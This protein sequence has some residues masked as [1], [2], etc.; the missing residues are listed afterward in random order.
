MATAITLK[1]GSGADTIN[2]SFVVTGINT[3]RL[4][5]QFADSVNSLLTGGNPLTLLH[6]F[7]GAGAQGGDQ[8]GTVQIYDLVPSTVDGVSNVYSVFA[9]GFIVDTISVARR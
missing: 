4:A 8:G 1:G 5:V 6:P 9:P 7:G 2:Y 3:T